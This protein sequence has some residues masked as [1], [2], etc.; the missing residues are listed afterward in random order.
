MLVLTSSLFNQIKS[1]QHGF[2]SKLGEA[3]LAESTS[4]DHNATSNQAKISKDFNYNVKFLRQI[5][6]NKVIAIE[7]PTQICNHVE[8]DALVTSL[9]Q[10]SLAIRTADCV[11]I[12]LCDPEN[13]II[14][15]SHAGWRGAFAGV[16]EKTIEQMT[17]LGAKHIYAVIGPCIR[18]QNYEV[19]QDF[20][21]NAI[22]INSKSLKFFTGSHKKGHYQFDL[23]GYC[24][25]MLK[26]LGVNANDLEVDTYSNSQLFFSYRRAYHNTKSGRAVKYGNQV[27]AIMIK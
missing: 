15:A 8:A 23:P 19:D 25:S 21:Q 14:G 27:S 12:L 5:H 7:T 4:L 10:V 6:S 17:Q 20:Y 3:N 2:F 9:P 1:I 22:K 13:S 11:P 24:S 26:D 18:A 16:I